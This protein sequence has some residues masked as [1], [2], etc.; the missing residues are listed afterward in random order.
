MS[1]TTISNAIIAVLKKGNRPLPVK[2][3]Y[4]QIVKWNLYEFKSTNPVNVISTEIRRHCQD[5]T[6]SAKRDIL[7]VKLSNKSY[8]LINETIPELPKSK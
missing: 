7:F 6:Q 1:K 2:E 3:I 5:S 8:W 4:D